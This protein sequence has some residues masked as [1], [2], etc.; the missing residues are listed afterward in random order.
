VD[1][2][3]VKFIDR[4]FGTAAC[5]ILSIFKR[6]KSF[7]KPK[8][9]L[10]VQVWGIGE[11]ILTLPALR[12]AKLKYPSAIVSVLCTARNRPVYDCAPYVDKIYE[13]KMG[14]AGLFKF[15]VESH[16]RFDV[17]LDM[18][19]YLNV[20]ALLAFFLGRYRVGYAGQPRSK[21]YDKVVPY[22]DGQHVAKTYFDLVRLI[23]VNA[24][25]DELEGLIVS[26]RSLSNVAGIMKSNC[27][28]K[29]DFLVGFGIGAA[30]SARC[31]IWPKERFA[32]LAD[33]LIKKYNAK[34]LFVGSEGESQEVDDVISMVRNKGSV[35]NLA[36]K[37]GIIDLFALIKN[38]DFFIGNDSGP[39]HVAACQ[40]VQTIGLFGPNHPAR[41]GPFGKNGRAIYMGKV[42]GFSPC[43]NVH[44]GKTPDCLFPGDSDDYQKCMKKISVDDVIA[45]VGDM[46]R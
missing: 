39:M 30:E 45:L 28:S 3:A 22:N 24:R 17:V 12:Y 6:K 34:I 27:L 31:R 41:F 23:G 5:Q 26:K 37:T 9:I 44:L 11:T 16:G 14:M 20:S 32:Q 2:A 4:Y 7:S 29:K 10:F 1:V 8:S 18:E 15:V 35:C 25:F 13:V 21:L 33:R 42:C 46:L 36:G 19:E 40:K 43:I 38:L